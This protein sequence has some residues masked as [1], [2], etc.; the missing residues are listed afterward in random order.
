MIINE[1]FFDEHELETDVVSSDDSQSF[2][3]KFMLVVK[4]AHIA[5]EREDI[6]KRL[7][8]IL[9]SNTQIDSFRITDVVEKP[10]RNKKDEINISFIAVCDFRSVKQVYD[11]LVRLYYGVFPKGMYAYDYFAVG[12]ANH[13]E[14]ISAFVYDIDYREAEKLSGFGTD[15]KHVF[16]QWD[17]FLS[18]MRGMKNNGESGTISS[19][20]DDMEQSF[21]EMCKFF[22]PDMT[23]DDD[24]Y[25][26]YLFSIMKPHLITC[27]IDAIGQYFYTNVKKGVTSVFEDSMTGD[28][29]IKVISLNKLKY[30]IST[31]N[32]LKSTDLYFATAPYKRTEE[33]YKEST[34]SN[35][36]T[37]MKLTKESDIK[38]I[39]PFMWVPDTN[40][41]WR[42]NNSYIRIEDDVKLKQIM[43]SYV[44]YYRDK[45]TKKVMIGVFITN[46][47]DI[48]KF[49]KIVSDLYKRVPH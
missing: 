8:Y 28:V 49:N 2:G 16:N 42:G 26:S 43:L 17:V 12:Y 25:I 3:T 22:I 24:V 32:N 40:S 13:D 44:G 30:K 11:F 36:I 34:Y 27:C 38:Y 4:S 10:H 20:L 37:I 7:S 29:E 48:S 5:A 15:N 47:N 33:E 14:E 23:S 46:T 39:E 6:I 21:S 41:F 35:D 1:D 45:T 18:R 9:K 19:E 31:Y